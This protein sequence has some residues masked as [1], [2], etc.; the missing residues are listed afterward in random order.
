MINLLIEDSLLRQINQINHTSL[1]N[2]IKKNSIIKKKRKKTM[3]NRKKLQ[4]M[5]RLRKWR[6]RK[7]KPR[8]IIKTGVFQK[9]ERTKIETQSTKIKE[10][11]LFPMFLMSLLITQINLSP[12]EMIKI[13]N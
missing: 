9:K 8:S 1:I 11:S 12:P 10:E 3:I 4:K 5:R 6:K 7:S 2:L 13:K